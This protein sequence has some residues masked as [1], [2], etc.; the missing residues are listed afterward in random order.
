MK[1]FCKKTAFT[2]VELMVTVAISAI[3]ILTAAAVLLM[4]YRSWSTN[5]AYVRLRRDAAFAIEIM[6][7]DIR[8]SY[9]NDITPTP[10]DTTL[11]LQNNDIRGYLAV[12]T[13]NSTNGT[14][15]YVRGTTPILLIPR[16]LRNFTPERVETNATTTGV[17]IR[18]EMEDDEF[19]IIITNETFIRIRN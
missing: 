5:N 11:T 16:G 1:T 9:P 18:L 12:F 19:D 14:L 8:E 10:T 13:E 7:R 17:N 6:A 2:L 3:V 4:T 15:S